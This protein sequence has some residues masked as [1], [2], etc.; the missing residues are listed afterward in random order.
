MLC[1]K[2]A[3]KGKKVT[4]NFSED[5]FACRY[6]CPPGGRRLRP[7]DDNTTKHRPHGGI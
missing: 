6:K 2:I 4:E 5:E 1:V 7:G 3:E